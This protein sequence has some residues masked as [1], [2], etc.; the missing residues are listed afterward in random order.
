MAKKTFRV[1]VLPGDGIGPEV[2]AEAVRVLEVISA[3]SQDIDIK[4]ETHQFGGSAIDVSGSSTSGEET[5]SEA[6]ER[7]VGPPDAPRRRRDGLGGA[8]RRHIRIE[9]ALKSFA[10]LLSGASCEMGMAGPLA[11]TISLVL[12]RVGVVC[13]SVGGFELVLERGWAL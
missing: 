9:V 11:M 4:L 5:G 6:G 12:R 2:T 1:V 3:A 10:L 8:I 13:R 7:D